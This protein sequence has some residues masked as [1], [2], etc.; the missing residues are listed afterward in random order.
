MI[1]LLCVMFAIL[2][3]GLN[4][5]LLIFN[6]LIQLSCLSLASW[7]ISAAML[8]T[9]DAG[10][11]VLAAGMLAAAWIILV[12]TV[13]GVFQ[14]L[15]ANLV[16]IAIA[17]LGLG[18]L[19]IPYRTAL[20]SFTQ[21]KSR[22]KTVIIGICLAFIT[23]IAALAL[24][25]PPNGHDGLAYHLPFAINYI[26]THQLALYSTAFMGN[27]SYYPANAELLDFFFI[28]TPHADYFANMVQVVFW[29]GSLLA[30]YQ[31]A[32]NVLGMERPWLVF[33]MAL[34]IAEYALFA[35][36]AYNDLVFG[37]FVLAGIYFGLRKGY[38]YTFIAALALGMALGVKYFAPLYV[39]LAAISILIWQG[40]NWRR[41][42]ANALILLGGCLLLGG[43]WY[44]RN[45]ALTGNP[46]YP[47]QIAIGNWVVFTGQG[48]FF[49]AAQGQ[50]IRIW[51]Q[52]SDI[53]LP[54]LMYLLFLIRSFFT[55]AHKNW[56]L[57][58]F[59]LL[60]F[61]S[62]VVL[63][64]R[65]VRYAFPA[66]L[67]G[68]A[69]SAQLVQNRLKWAVYAYLLLSIVFVG[70]RLW[71]LSSVLLIALVVL[72]GITVTGLYIRNRLT[73]RA[74]I[75]WAAWAVCSGF[76]V[77]WTIAA[78]PV[79][80]LVRYRYFYTES[81]GDIAK[82]WQWLDEN[83]PAGSK[84]AYAGDNRLAPLYGKH[85]ERDVVY[86]NVNDKGFS[87]AEPAYRI[88]K[89]ENIWLGNL[90]NA[91]IDYLMVSPEYS[92]PGET[93]RI[94][95][96]ALWAKDNQRFKLVFKLNDVVL[97]ALNE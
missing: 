74:W 54:V 34:L 93:A 70:Y 82:A 72:F 48:T 96:E 17:A 28:A 84:I 20:P 87:T 41:I 79:R 47:A 38:T 92:A 66:V 89:D 6:F 37:G 63:P 36:S 24:I 95:A 18:S 51:E 86:V 22:I 64:F 33:A 97:Y 83:V 75:R 15:Y 49:N 25:R 55:K 39:M 46:L 60:Y 1:S 80:D 26:K 42:I 65:E 58:I 16:A 19:F 68:V 88:V 7:R 27:L 91:G 85:F 23:L 31:L 11:K 35:A 32:K 77:M 5:T 10:D 43:Y 45:W 2:P 90:N 3:A 67:L 21:E 53:L 40:G 81:L 14:I 9:S 94:P 57:I 71:G 12:T 69:L 4:S 8:P 73:G 56:L 62:L 29:L 13:L 52:L 59:P 61:L 30:V 50:N 44:I 76:I 78:E